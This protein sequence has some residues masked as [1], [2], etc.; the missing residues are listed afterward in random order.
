M[1]R[2]FAGGLYVKG[3]DIGGIKT[4]GPRLTTA[5]VPEH[6]IPKF[7]LPMPSFLTELHPHTDPKRERGQQTSSPNTPPNPQS[8]QETP[9]PHTNPKRERGQRTSSPKEPP[10]VCRPNEFP[11]SVDQNP[12]RF[13]AINPSVIQHPLPPKHGISEFSRSVDQRRPWGSGSHRPS[14]PQHRHSR[15]FLE[16]VDQK[17][18][19][20]HTRPAKDSSHHAPS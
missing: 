11:D 20:Y 15:A 1:F 4:A 12:S 13:F 19:P 8:G 9:S 16:F 7:P 10:R 5:D 3:S 2:L 6:L 18:P 14:P 17:P